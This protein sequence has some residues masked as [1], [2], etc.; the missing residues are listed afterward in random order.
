MRVSHTFSLMAVNWLS[1]AKGLDQVYGCFKNRRIAICGN[2]IVE[3][4]EICDCGTAS[5]CNERCCTPYGVAGTPCTLRNE[6]YQCSTSRGMYDLQGC[7]SPP[8][9]IWKVYSFWV[10]LDVLLLFLL[11][12]KTSAPHPNRNFLTP[13]HLALYL[14][15]MP[16]DLMRHL[17]TWFPLH[18]VSGDFK[19]E[20]DPPC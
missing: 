15:I 18:L 2:G 19:E 10:Y 11:F 13:M 14:L 1:D 12:Q 20:L 7:S 8:P 3:Y 4:P 17:G 6:A 16:Q 5:T 9:I